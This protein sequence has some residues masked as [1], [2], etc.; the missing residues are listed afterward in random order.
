MA[1]R[2]NALVKRSSATSH[3]DLFRFA[4]IDD[5]RTLLD[6]LP[7]D[8]VLA[9]GEV[10]VA[11]ANPQLRL[12]LRSALF[13]IS[14]VSRCARDVV[15]IPASAARRELDHASVPSPCAATPGRQMARPRSRAKP[16]A[17][18]VVRLVFPPRPWLRRA[19]PARS[20]PA[21][22]SALA[23][24]AADGCSVLADRTPSIDTPLRLSPYDRSPGHQGQPLPAPSQ[25]GS[26]QKIFKKDPATPEPMPPWTG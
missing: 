11:M 14:R 13:R 5:P 10:M 16:A 21:R 25:P 9:R 19:A 3:A 7:R 24:H 18:C 4:R 17:A 12:A 1:P 8:A 6:P 23:R 22:L 20:A 2:T 15:Q 26:P